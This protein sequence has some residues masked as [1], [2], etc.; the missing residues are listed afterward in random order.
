[1]MEKKKHPQE[2]LQISVYADAQW[3]LRRGSADRFSR[4][5]AVIKIRYG[6][7]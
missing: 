2:E 1:M 3:L 5:E 7:L 6:F 4:G